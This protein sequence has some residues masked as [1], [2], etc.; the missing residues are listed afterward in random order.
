MDAPAEGTSA[1]MGGNETPET[2]S[3]S[4]RA[5][6]SRLPSVMNHA[7]CWETLTAAELE[8]FIQYSGRCIA[9]AKKAQ[10]KAKAASV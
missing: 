6:Y 2:A 7:G 4:V 9:Q 8:R 3:E 1:P 5:I 10:T